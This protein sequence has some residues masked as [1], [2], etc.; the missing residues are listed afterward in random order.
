MTSFINLSELNGTNGFVI[1]G[2]GEGDFSGNSVSNAG[3]VNGDGFDDILIGATGV[4]FAGILVS[5]AG[6]SYVVFSNSG[7]FD[8]S[9][10][11][12]S[13]DSTSGLV[14]TGRGRY[15][16][17]G[18]SVSS[19]GDING[20]GFDDIII[21][22]PLSYANTPFS[23]SGETYVIFGRNTE[24]NIS[25]GFVI[26]GIGTY[27]LGESVSGAGDINGDGIDDII[28]G[29][30]GESYV[31]FGN[32]GGFDSGF[33][34][35]DLDGSNGFTISSGGSVSGAG[36]INGDGI[37]D[38]IIGALG[39]DPNGIE[40]AGESYVVFGNSG[41]FDS[42]FELSDLDGSNGFVINGIDEGD[43]SG[44]S[45]SGAGDINGDG[46][47]D[48][49][50][51][52]D[53]AD[54]NGI[55]NAGESYIVFGNSEFD[56]SLE[57]SNLDGS[58]GFVL[59]GIDQGDFS[60][61]SVSG[62]GDINGDGFDDVIIG[63]DRADPDGIENAGESYIVFGASE[64]DPSLEL[65]SLNNRNG[66]VIEGID[67]GDY[68]GDSVSGAGDVNGDGFDDIII[69]A[70]GADANRNENAGESYVI[71]GFNVSPNGVD[72]IVNINE[73]TVFNGNVL[74]NDTDPN[75]NTLAVIEV[76]AQ[77][78]DIGS[79]ITL[80]SGALLTLNA[81]GT[82]SYDTNGQFGF[83]ETGETATDSFT[84]TVIG[85]TNTDIATVNITITPKGTP[86]SAINLSDLDGSNG[87]VIEG[88]N[89]YDSSGG[90]VSSAG[91][92]NGDGFDDIIIGAT[93]ADYGGESYVVF[94][95]SNG[96]DQRLNLSDLDGSNG[97]V[98]NGIDQGDSAGGSVSSGGDVNG[99]GIDDIIIGASSADPNGNERAGES[100]I[101]FGNSNGFDASLNL[102]DLDGSNGFVIEGIDERDYSGRSVSGAGDINGDGFDDI[103]IGA[104]DA[105]PNGNERAGE[106][107]VVFGNSNGF[108]ASLN[109]SDLDG[110]N[111]FVIEG[112]DER[113]SSGRSVSNAGDVNGDG[114]DDII[115][116][117]PGAAGGESYVVFGSNSGF[118]ERLNLSELDGSNGFTI[119]SGEVVSSGGDINGDGIDD[120]IIGAPFASPNGSFYAGES[121]VVF[122][123][124]SGFDE[125]LNLSELDGS[126]G[127]A[128]NNIRQF[129]FLGFSVSSAGDVNGDGID[130]IL[131][132]APQADYS[133]ESYV[134]FGNSNGFD[135]S[136]DLSQLN[137]SNGFVLN[138]INSGDS[139][140]GSVSGAGDINGDGFDDIIIGASGAGYG[141]ES[142]VVFG[143][144]PAPNAIDDTVNTREDAI[145]SENVLDNDTDANGNT[146]T[147]TEVNNQTTD[148]GDQITLASG[149]LLTLNADGTFSYDPNGQ[150]DFLNTGETAIDSFTYTVSDRTDTDIA[151]VNITI[152]GIDQGSPAS[153]INVSNLNGSNG[154]TINGID[155]FDF[156]GRSVSGAGDVN[157]DGIDDIIIGATDADPNGNERAGESYV[158]FGR[159][160]GF[161]PSL[162]LSD[163]DGSN[164]FVINGIDENDSSGISLSNAGDIN[165]DG[166]DDII[167]GADGADPNGIESAGE[168]Y[169]VFGNSN[170]FEASLELSNLDG[171][172]GFV[173]NGIDERDSSGRSVS[174]AGDINGDGFDD[175]IIG[176]FVGDPNGNSRAGESYVVFGNSNGFEASLELSS[177]DGSNG[178]TINGID[179]SDFSGISVSNAGDINA[180]GIDDIII[181]APGA[182]YGGESY[183]VFG[184]NNGFDPS[185]ELSDLDGSN[186]FTINGIDEGDFSGNSVSSAGDVNGDG[187]DDIIIG[188]I[189]ADPNGELNAGES[190]VVFGSNNGFE[191]S[192]ELSDLDGSN[193][194]TIN[195]INP[196]DYSGDFVSGAG[197]FNGDGFDDILIGNVNIDFYSNSSISIAQSYVVFGNSSG[198]ASLDLSDLNGSNGLVINGLISNDNSGHSGSNAGDINGDGF[199]DIILGNIRT[200]PN[201]NSYAGNSYVIFGFSTVEESLNL[202]GSNREDTLLGAGGDDTIFGD[203]DDDQLLGAA[204]DDIL[205]G[206]NGR[207][208]LEGEMGNDTLIGGNGRDV[209]NGGVGNDSLIGNNGRDTLDGGLGNDT[210]TGGNSRDLFVLTVGEGVDTITDFRSSDV[211]GLAEGLEFSDLSFTGNDIILTSTNQVLATLIGVQ[212]N[213]LSMDEFTTI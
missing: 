126:N 26:N 57:L 41:E 170:G 149:A 198:E 146:L 186:G 210:L 201:G 100:Y 67:Q 145:V 16:S 1:N 31:V 121:Y 138:G 49:I 183:L 64:F 14:I 150:F 140:G 193:G 205:D 86:V 109:L 72:D 132:G 55:E 117:A 53:R 9:F 125:R 48:I 61:S 75:G 23:R 153:L 87:F 102:S 189:Y 187:I 116:S 197:D 191:A 120:I 8:A 66:F 12:S 128:L 156:S 20:D 115:I 135:P 73:N 19:A 129:N 167:I 195:G 40:S 5:F 185:L 173:I 11:L 111:G 211:I 83:L 7:R 200:N 196:R 124:N 118:D 137:G 65:S 212:T 199:D 51:G 42:S 112:I 141:G 38:I 168:S 202:V 105:D 154:F 70:P 106:S 194:F 43:F 92:V 176:A 93:G 74:D 80:A 166:I 46:F 15:D 165:G 180:D 144:Q 34:L 206:D 178:F 60:G 29:A 2:I 104:D 108:D 123:S 175:I 160:N 143:F 151:T 179:E 207:D 10:E 77:A 208:T 88:I 71:F 32:S 119:S 37:D 213:S 171:S 136:L 25:N 114:I 13:L 94:G 91:D 79:Q 163:L 101:V 3:D 113:D 95:N 54:P 59:N 69:G 81:D 182:G 181:G 28:I 169:V 58:N 204:G 110:S 103:I 162:E 107:Y 36:D 122:G 82:F 33:E 78:T 18:T 17:L 188:A 203:N 147:V 84:Y 22:A 6:E 63:A 85:G 134:V 97:F 152:N 96:F 157:G 50:I 139:S 62:A 76:N 4:K 68:S 98:I 148:V 209:L 131:I 130:D 142:Y 161:D 172:N 56:P 44:R 27:N 158:V 190:Y 35:S 127:F 30:A 177:L 184:R 99:D 192:L 90:S 155:E 47:D 133:G 89:E 24:S 174:N 52:A 164:G 159:N 39:A 45:V 21:G